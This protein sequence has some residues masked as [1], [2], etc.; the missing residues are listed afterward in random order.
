LR[1][2]RVIQLEA[3]SGLV[4][5]VFL[6]QELGFVASKSVSRKDELDLLHMTLDL[7]KLSATGKI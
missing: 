4:S 6:Y 2:K 5:A 1:E 3:F 7:P